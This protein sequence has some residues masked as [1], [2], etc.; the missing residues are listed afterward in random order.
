VPSQNIIGS[1]FVDKTEEKNGRLEIMRTGTLG[2][3]NDKDGKP[4]GIVRHIGRRP[5]LSV[6]NERNGGDIAHLRYS[7]EGSGPNMQIMVNHDDAERE[8]AYAE[9]DG[10][11]LAAAKKF[12]FKVLSMKNDWKQIFP[13]HQPI[14]SNEKK[15]E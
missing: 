1:F 8:A 7:A 12:G 14:A 4:V 5:I 9:K 3:M 13:I 11:S 15:N 6:G 10:A 2:M